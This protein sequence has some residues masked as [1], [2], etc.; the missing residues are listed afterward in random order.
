MRIALA[1]LCLSLPVFAQPG[2]TAPGTDA[3]ERAGA[4]KAKKS[5]DEKAA[6]KKKTDRKKPAD[7]APTDKT[8]APPA[9]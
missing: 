7:T 3:T 2:Q 8:A 9:K 5:E 6:K 4:A 1:L